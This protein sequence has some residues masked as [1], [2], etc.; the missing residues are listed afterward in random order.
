MAETVSGRPPRI[1]GIDGPDLPG[2]RSQNLP[3]DHLINTYGSIPVYPPEPGPQ[4]SPTS[5]AE[6]AT[7]FPKITLSARNAPTITTFFHPL[8]LPAS[9]QRNSNIVEN[10]FIKKFRNCLK[11]K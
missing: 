1:A 6:D 9:A 7:T 5:T 8:P 10:C 3:E 2:P 4:D 11:K